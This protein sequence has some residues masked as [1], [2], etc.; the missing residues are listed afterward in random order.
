MAAYR[1]NWKNVQQAVTDPACGYLFVANVGTAQST[2]FEAEINFKP[3]ESLLLTASGS[4]THAEFKS[5]DAAFQGASAEQA[6]DAVPDVP[7]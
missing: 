7:R 4:Y 2:G 5:I 6:G 1:I 3:T